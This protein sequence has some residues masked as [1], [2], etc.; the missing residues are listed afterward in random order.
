MRSGRWC[1]VLC[2]GLLL[3][4]KHESSVTLRSSCFDVCVDAS[5]N[6]DIEG[7]LAIATDIRNGLESARA[8]LSGYASVSKALTQFV[9]SM[10]EMKSGVPSGLR[11]AGAGI[12]E[13]Q[14]NADTS[15]ELRFYL[16]SNTSYGKAGDLIQFDVFDPSNY[17]TSLGVKASTTVSLSGISTNLSF[18]FDK[19]GPGAELLGIGSSASSP[20]LIDVGAFS[21]QLSKVTVRAQVDVAHPSNTGGVELG[22]SPTQVPVAAVGNASSQLSIENFKAENGAFDQT[23]TLES[24]ALTFSSSSSKFE[25]A[26]RAKS[27]SPD[28][29]FAIS[30][31]YDL[32][33]QG[34]IQ[35][36]CL[37]TSL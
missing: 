17:F 16:P 37:G 1:S 20:L 35:L 8:G 5:A 6:V 33:A 10:V 25:G 9:Q 3:G 19:L 29:G 18:T 23:V 4:C 30:I 32:D 36:G 7:Q 21:S 12:Y 13:L 24:A 22:L 27:T 2:V 26:I 28:F 15:V 14:P 31:S 11:Y 34:D